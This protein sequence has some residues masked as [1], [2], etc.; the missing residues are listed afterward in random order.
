VKVVLL[1]DLSKDSVLPAF[2][3]SVD[4]LQEK[5]E[6]STFPELDELFEKEFNC[7][8]IYDREKS[9]FG[10]MW[11]NDANYSWFMLRWM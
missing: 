8:L 1:K 10:F 9:V 4:Y 6:V 2:R 5:Y 7:T 3:R 11:D